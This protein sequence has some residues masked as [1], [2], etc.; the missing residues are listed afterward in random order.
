MRIYVTENKTLSIFPSWTSPVRPRSP[1]PNSGN[2]K[3]LYIDPIDP[4]ECI[5]RGASMS[6]CT[7]RAIFALDALVL[8]GAR[9]SPA[10]IPG[11][12]YDMVYERQ[13]VAPRGFLVRAGGHRQDLPPHDFFGS[14]RKIE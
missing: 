14:L 12:V 8:H 9:K 2:W 6:V 1:A 10:L 5:D 3:W 11:F 4:F 7:V 13:A